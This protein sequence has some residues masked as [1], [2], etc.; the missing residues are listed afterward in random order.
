MR[1]VR[2]G[3]GINRTDHPEDEETQQVP[4][5]DTGARRQPIRNI[6]ITIAENPT[7]EDRRDTAAIVRL[8][9][10]VDDSNDRSDQNVKA[11]SSDTSGSADVNGKSNEVFDRSTAVE[12]NHHG[13]NRGSD[14]CGDDTMP[15][16]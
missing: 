16:E 11:G 12:D 14:Y 8:R 4:R 13:Q 1:K 9:C 5:C 15:P 2:T 6:I 3:C 7:H 10:E